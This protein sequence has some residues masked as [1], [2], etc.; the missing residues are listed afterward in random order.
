STNVIYN[1]TVIEWPKVISITIPN[2]LSLNVGENYTFSPVIAEPGANTTLSWSSTNP[3]VATVY[4]GTVQ[5][6]GPGT[7]TIICT[8][9]NGVSAQCLVTV[10]AFVDPLPAVKDTT[11]NLT[12]TE[13][14]PFVITPI[15][16]LNIAEGDASTPTPYIVSDPSACTVASTDCAGWNS[17]IYRIYTITPVKAGVFVFKETCS[18]TIGYAAAPSGTYT[19]TATATYIV[20]VVES[21]PMVLGDMDGD[22]RVTVG[23][24]TKVIDIY[25]EGTGE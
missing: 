25:L 21:L 14:I 23:D 9:E 13:G 18:C 3:G 2:S 4:N 11:V 19:K 20:N 6:V 5:A 24:V 22:G 1:I 17:G 12:V 16:E 7:A 10:N 8:A 15:H